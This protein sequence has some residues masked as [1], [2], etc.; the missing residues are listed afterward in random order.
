MNNMKRSSIFLDVEML[1]FKLLQEQ[2]VF[3]SNFIYYNN[4]LYAH[5]EDN[6]I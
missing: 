3:V 6:N 4:N 5:F 1:Q 2:V